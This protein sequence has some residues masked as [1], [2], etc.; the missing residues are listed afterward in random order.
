MLAC[1]LKLYF[2]VLYLGLPLFFG[3]FVEVLLEGFDNAIVVVAVL[4][5]ELAEL[6]G[7]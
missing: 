6:F 7:G 4:F 2:F 5:P 3:P 1:E